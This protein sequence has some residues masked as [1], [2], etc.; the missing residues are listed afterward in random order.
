M[1]LT[2]L[3]SKVGLPP[4]AAVALVCII[5]TS[6]VYSDGNTILTHYWDDDATDSAGN[7]VYLNLYPSDGTLP[8][9]TADKFMLS[10]NLGP[11]G[12]NPEKF[13][14]VGSYYNNPAF[15]CVGYLTYDDIVVF[16][17]VTEGGSVYRFP[18][19][20][21][22]GGWGNANASTPAL[23]NIWDI[24]YM[25]T[26]DGREPTGLLMD[27]SFGRMTVVPAS[28][29]VSVDR[30]SDYQSGVNFGS[31]DPD[32]GVWVEC[33]Y[34]TTAIIG[35][36]TLPMHWYQLGSYK[37]PRLEGVVSGET[38][39]HKLPKDALYA[40]Y[41]AYTTLY[42]WSMYKEGQGYPYNIGTTN[43]LYPRNQ[44]NVLVEVNGNTQEVMHYTNA[45][46]E[47]GDTSTRLLGYIKKHHIEKGRSMVDIDDLQLTPPELYYPPDNTGSLHIGYKVDKGFYTYSSVSD[48]V[49]YLS[50]GIDNIDPALS[51]GGLK[52]SGSLLPGTNLLF[53]QS[54][55]IPTYVGL[56]THRCIYL[57]NTSA[58]QD[59][60]G[61]KLWVTKTSE[62]ISTIELGDDI[63]GVNIEVPSLTTEYATPSVTNFTLAIS[64]DSC[65][66][67]PILRKGEYIAIWLKRSY[68]PH[69]TKS[70]TP[71]YVSLHLAVLNNKVD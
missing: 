39:R 68:T 56:K 50:G 71:E 1:Q 54:D 19:D 67:L 5:V 44:C 11:E 25:H 24:P 42:Y 8:I 20:P 70:I 37:L 62:V 18:S 64:K 10:V 13:V 14:W 27:S 36:L 61:I 46:T 32:G 47:Y 40:I 16:P 30:K 15:Y 35:Y 28:M 58:T 34:V 29:D 3:K 49:I 66:T 38:Y 7:G 51:I 33:R 2:S 57:H 41:E 60:I 65:Y 55:P 26:I 59:A 22:L 17:E 21:A 12:S 4:E 63:A 69:S 48:L 45:G 53:Q 9:G 52:S 23:Q 31:F 6:T 43:P